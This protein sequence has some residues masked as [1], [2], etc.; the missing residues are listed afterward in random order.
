LADPAVEAKRAPASPAAGG[1]AKKKIRSRSDRDS[2]ESGHKAGSPTVEEPSPDAKELVKTLTEVRPGALTPAAAGAWQR[3]LTKLLGL[4]TAAVPALT[5]FFNKHE[6]VRFDAGPGPNLLGESSLRIAFLK[7]LFD[8]PGPANVELQARVLKTAT[9]PAEIA[10]IARQ[11]EQQEP[12]KHEGMII[13]AAREAL[14]IARNGELPGRDTR[15]L[16]ELLT[17]YVGPDGK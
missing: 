12:G 9:D 10:L 17:K 6:D 3:N 4:G 1:T 7:V 11:L 15:P 8:I 2:T 5:E 16:V 14:E 13:E